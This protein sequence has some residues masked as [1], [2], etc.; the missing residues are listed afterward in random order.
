[1]LQTLTYDLSLTLEYNKAVVYEASKDT[2]ILTSAT[3]VVEDAALEIE[4]ALLC[5]QTIRGDA[6]LASEVSFTFELSDST[7]ITIT[8]NPVAWDATNK[9]TLYSIN[10]NH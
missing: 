2:S 3:Y 6:C 1:M 9:L 5:T 4:Y 10:P 7:S 8:S